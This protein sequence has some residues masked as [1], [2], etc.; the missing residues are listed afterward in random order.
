MNEYFTYKE[1]DM[2]KV[3]IATVEAIKKIQGLDQVRVLSNSARSSFINCRRKFLY[4]YIYCLKPNEIYIPFL[5]GSLFHSELEHL[6]SSPSTWSIKT[7]D[8]RVTAEI[9]K[10]VKLSTDEAATDKLWSQ[11]AIIIGMLKGYKNWYKGDEF[12][13]KDIKPEM[14]FLVDIPHS[15]G[16][17]YTGKVDLNFLLKGK[18]TLC[19]HKTTSSLDVNYISRLPLD[20]QILGYLWGFSEFIGVMPHSILY[21]V[22]KKTQ[23]RQGKN[24]K[25][26][27][28]LKR[29]SDDYSLYKEK[30]YY[31]EPLR[32]G[33]KEIRAFVVELRKLTTEMDR[34]F[35]D[36][37]YYMNSSTC[38]TYGKCAYM[39]LC[40]NGVNNDTLSRYRIKD[41][42][43]EELEE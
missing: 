25:F 26:N 6:Y 27:D 10:S 22:V 4:E 43:H 34:A 41:R 36:D 33:T 12:K 28:Y 39:P 24:E 2:K 37:F 3:K 5:I 14:Q 16:W 21:N 38:T 7:M 40:L 31:R 1:I 23:L 29:V 9:R 18:R 19:E 42:I 32:F 11:R 30:Y 15:N 8:K 13:W 35:S 20:F 17:K